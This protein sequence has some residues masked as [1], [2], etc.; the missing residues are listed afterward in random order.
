MSAFDGNAHVESFN[1]N[2]GEY[3]KGKARRLG[4]E[5]LVP[6]RMTRKWLTR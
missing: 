6:H 5:A 1:G 3:E 2:F 4:P